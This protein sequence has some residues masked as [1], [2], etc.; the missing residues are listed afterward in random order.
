MTNQDAR[1]L[2][3]RLITE[4]AGQ[5]VHASVAQSIEKWAEELAREA[6]DEP[7]FRQ[8]WRAQVREVTAALMAALQQPGGEDRRKSDP[9][10]IQTGPR[11]DQGKTSRS[12]KRKGRS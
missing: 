6:L 8:A 2:L 1:T 5:A 4:R 12:R 11:L 9:K 3:D 7:G 10:V